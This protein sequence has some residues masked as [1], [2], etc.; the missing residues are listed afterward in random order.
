MASHSKNCNPP[1]II[2]DDSII[3]NNNCQKTPNNQANTF[4]DKTKLSAKTPFSTL[5]F[6][7]QTLTPLSRFKEKVS[8]KIKSISPFSR[9]RAEAFISN[10]S[11]LE[12]LANFK[13]KVESL[14]LNEKYIIR[15][16]QKFL[17]KFLKAAKFDPKKA[18][19]RY[20]SYYK[21]LLNMPNVE[22][23]ISDNPQDR[24][25]L[26]DAINDIGNETMEKLGYPSFGFYG[27]DQHGRAII[28]FDA[29][30]TN[31]FM[32]RKHFV[33]V[34]LYGAI[35][36]FD[37]ILEKYDYCQDSGFI[38][39]DDWKQMNLKVFD[40][41]RNNKTF[42]N[43]FREIISGSMPI[44]IKQYYIVNGP[45][46]MNLVYKAAKFFLSEKVRSRMHFTGKIKVVEND[47]G[48]EN[49]PIF[50]GGQKKHLEMTDFDI[51]K[52]LT[53]IFPKRRCQR[54]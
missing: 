42:A 23:I 43:I 33:N 35:L 22:D 45:R 38:M 27:Q 4:I 7:S 18:L 37:Y 50:L 32:D 39:V 8:E 20:E 3:T 54:E 11:K 49:L 12:T 10:N 51:E 48:K 13:Q 29:S 6:S 40:F 16:D 44:R 30:A 15:T 19:K 52:Q 5:M 21:L 26:I 1:N 17:T 36:T 41:L 47:M 31:L 14:P 46:L 9:P 28:A 53:K 25:W 34:A 24:R 2:I